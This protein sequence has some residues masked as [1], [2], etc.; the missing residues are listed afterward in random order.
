M[1]IRLLAVGTRMPDWV[2]KGFE[3]YARRLPRGQ[4]LLLEE[5]PRPRA[6]ADAARARA[7]EGERLLARISPRD[8]VIALD[9]RGESWSTSC[10]ADNMRSWRAAGRDVALLIGG[11]DGLASACL[12]RADRTWSLSA[13]TLP[14]ALARVLVAEQLYRAWTLQSGHPYHRA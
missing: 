12:A 14:H 13:L 5:V 4:P 1:K 7:L 8:W 2:Q 11:P 9:E 6:A 10:V 3:T